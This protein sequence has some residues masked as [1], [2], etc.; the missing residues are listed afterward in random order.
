MSR[1]VPDWNKE[2][3]GL[4]IDKIGCAGLTES[5]KEV[6][7]Q[8][9]PDFLVTCRMLYVGIEM[10]RA[11]R[12][13]ELSNR[14]I[15]RAAEVLSKDAEALAVKLSKGCGGL[16]GEIRHGGINPKEVAETLHALA[17]ICKTAST[18][19]DTTRLPSL[20]GGTQGHIELA[21]W[22]RFVFEEKLESKATIYWNEHGGKSLYVQVLE[23]CFYEAVGYTPPSI[24]QYMI[25]AKKT[26][27][28]PIDDDYWVNMSD[29]QTEAIKREVEDKFS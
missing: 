27:L 11:G 10:Y 8:E 17:A 6:I 23:I 4:D 21:R 15:L 13:P 1:A 12:T 20:F 28:P 26:A 3:C 5:L 19:T 2:I 18:R 9:P 16:W 14:Q 7:D 22:V 24:K 29:E 25:T